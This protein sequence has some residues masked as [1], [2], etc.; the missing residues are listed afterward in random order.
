M[1]EFV[2]GTKTYK[3]I[4]FN[5]KDQFLTEVKSSFSHVMQEDPIVIQQV[6]LAVG[7]LAMI[8]GSIS[9]SKEEIEER[10]EVA[11][12]QEGTDD[13]FL[14]TLYVFHNDWLLLSE[15]NRLLV[16]DEHKIELF[17]KRVDITV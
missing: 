15:D 9:S 3:G 12:I 4:C 5:K 11:V 13:D 17:S 10:S 6:Q 2:K 16:V 14:Q 7:F 8:S 1:T